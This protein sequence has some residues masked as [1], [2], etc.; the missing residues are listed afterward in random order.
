MKK[1]QNTPK[2]KYSKPQLH[3]IAL[4]N[5]ISLVM[6]T[7]ENNIPNPPPWMLDAKTKADPFKPNQA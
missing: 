3:K 7:D 1:N 2:L 4:D 6:M 5:A